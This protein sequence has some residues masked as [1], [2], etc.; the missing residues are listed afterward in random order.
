MKRETFETGRSIELFVEITD[1]KG[2]V[3]SDCNN[4]S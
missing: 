4:A 2:Q 1:K 3:I